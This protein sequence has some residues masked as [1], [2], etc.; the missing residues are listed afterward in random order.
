MS[1]NSASQ[2]SRQVFSTTASP[3]RTLMSGG[4]HPSFCS[5]HVQVP[6]LE[7][8]VW[9][10]EQHHRGIGRWESAAGREALSQGRLPGSSDT[11]ILC[12]PG[13]EPVHCHRP[14]GDIA[15]VLLRSELGLLSVRRSPEKCKALA[16]PPVAGKSSTLTGVTAMRVEAV[17]IPLMFSHLSP[18]DKL[19]LRPCYHIR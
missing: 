14:L 17:S 7:G 12:R 18:P 19:K 5:V 2:I 9:E 13:R 11:A 10:P 15:F 8:G 3:R 6:F 1:F 4:A 16:L